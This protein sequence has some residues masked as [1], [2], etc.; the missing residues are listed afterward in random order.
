M[1]MGLKLLQERAAAEQLHQSLLIQQQPYI[2]HQPTSTSPSTKSSW[3]T[4]NRKLSLTPATL[5]IDDNA[6]TPT[7]T[8]PYPSNN[9]TNNTTSN[10]VDEEMLEDMIQSGDNAVNILDDLLLY[11]KIEGN[12]FN[13]QKEQAHI[14]T[15]INDVIK[16]FKQQALCS[17]IQLKINT[18][19]INN[20][21]S[22]IDIPNFMTLLRNILSNA[23]KFTNSTEGV[24]EIK[25]QLI[26][27]F[28]TGTGVTMG[29]A[30]SV[31]TGNKSATGGSF[32]STLMN[33]VMNNLTIDN[34]CN[35]TAKNTCNNSRDGGACRAGRGGDSPV[36]QPRASPTDSTNSGSNSESTNDGDRSPDTSG[37][38]RSRATSYFSKT[39]TTTNT[40]TN[41]TTTTTHN[42][43]LFVD[44]D[45]NNDGETTTYANHFGSLQS[46]AG[47]DTGRSNTGRTAAATTNDSSSSSKKGGALLK[48]QSSKVIPKQMLRITISDN[49]VGI[50]KV[51]V[52]LLHL[53]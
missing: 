33:H 26:S 28:S 31:K 36:R 32:K 34:T 22:D 20:V 9:T 42:Y 40:T 13:M 37:D 3:H 21:Y 24:V 18:N 4:W 45:T 53:Y 1:L 17:N 6:H 43:D 5:N 30:K 51:S 39:N 25:A 10:I 2:P 27:H 41:A 47:T 16:Q 19:E 52:Q 50:A 11:E 38:K 14:S 44:M 23:F 35:N 46:S 8:H 49:G 12:L 15:I 48:R 7:P 29:D